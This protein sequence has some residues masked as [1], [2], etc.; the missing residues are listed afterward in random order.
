MEIVICRGVE[1]RSFVVNAMLIL[2]RGIKEEELTE[3]CLS[4]ISAELDR[5]RGNLNYP[6]SVLRT[7]TLPS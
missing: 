3:Y 6:Y 4:K 7:R 1:C 5:L 2:R